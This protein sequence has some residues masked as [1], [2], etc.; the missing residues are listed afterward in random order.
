MPIEFRPILRIDTTYGHCDELKIEFRE[1]DLIATVQYYRTVGTFSRAFTFGFVQ[2]HSLYSEMLMPL[3]ARHCID[4][5]CEVVGS[6]WVE[7]YRERVSTD[8][9]GL[10][11]YAIYFTKCGYLEVLSHRLE[12]GPEIA[13][14]DPAQN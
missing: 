1:M 12:I 10:R 8:L 5:L 3:T 7:R 9:R 4:Q 13:V 14:A 11:H 2:T 6:E